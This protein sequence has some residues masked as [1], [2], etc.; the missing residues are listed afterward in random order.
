MR[1][2]LLIFRKDV[3]HRRGAVSAFLLLVMARMAIDILL[4]RHSEL[5]GAQTALGILFLIAAIGLIY[6]RATGAD[7][8]R[9]S[10]LADASVSAE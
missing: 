2:A 1:D 8:G 4:P 5:A 6:V 10:I 9:G 7:R 3:D